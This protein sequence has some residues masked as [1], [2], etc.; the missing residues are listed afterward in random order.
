MMA[1]SVVAHFLSLGPFRGPHEG[2]SSPRN[3]WVPSRH[4]VLNVVIRRLGHRVPHLSIVLGYRGIRRIQ[5]SISSNSGSSST[6][7]NCSCQSAGLPR[8]ARRRDVRQRPPRQVPARRPTAVAR[9]RRRRG[10]RRE[11]PRRLACRSNTLRAVSKN[12]CDATVIPIANRVKP[13][14]EQS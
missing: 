5:R 9:R 13:H 12:R 4:W 3:S 11:A 8:V 10:R 14:C 7:S 6:V 2:I 1:G